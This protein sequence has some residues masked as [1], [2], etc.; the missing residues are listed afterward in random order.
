VYAPRWHWE[1]HV[2]DLEPRLFYHLR[3]EL[4]AR[5]LKLNNG[6]SFANAQAIMIDP[7]TGTLSGGSDPGSGT[8]AVGTS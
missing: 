5:G 4:E 8:G 1:D 2:V 3:A 7:L 6:G